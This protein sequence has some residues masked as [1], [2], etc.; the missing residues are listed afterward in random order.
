[1]YH[2]DAKNKERIIGKM[3]TASNNQEVIERQIERYSSEMDELQGM[4]HNHDPRR[5][6]NFVKLKKGICNG[7]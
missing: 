4:K 3:I 1:L 5:V 6:I 2:L 7:S